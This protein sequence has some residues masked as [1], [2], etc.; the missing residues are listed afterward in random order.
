MFHREGW[1][2]RN[3]E[4]LPFPACLLD[5]G[6][7]LL[8]AS[9]AMEDAT[10]HPENHPAEKGP[11]SSNAGRDGLAADMV[12]YER[13]T[14][15][16][17]R[18]YLYV[19]DD[20]IT[21]DLWLWELVQPIIGEM[22]MGV[23]LTDV[24]LRVRATNSTA[25]KML[26]LKADDA[27]GRV[28]SEAVPELG[29]VLR[30]VAHKIAAEGVRNLLFDAEIDGQI[31]H[32]LLDSHVFP[33]FLSPEGS[34]EK[35][36]VF[37]L[38]DLGERFENQL[39]RQEKLAT[40]GKIAAGIAHEIRN[41]LTS[42]KGFLQIMRENFIRSH[43]DKEFQYTEVMLAEIDR[44]NELVG[45]LLLLSRPRDIKLASMEV[46]EL[47]TGLAP[48]ISSETLLHDIEFHLCIKPVPKVLA[49]PELLKQVVLNLVKNAVEAMEHGGT[50]TLCTDV[51]REENLV[52][53]D[54]QDTGPGIPA[55]AM[56]R[57]FDAFFTTKENGTGLGLPICQRIIS[58]LGGMIRVSSKG[59]GTTFSVL[60]PAYEP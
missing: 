46:E 24:D 55:Y 27:I 50:L 53:I 26:H 19:S 11:E 31:Q 16:G 58:D 30:P 39:Q 17:N 49:D 29:L 59:Y 38:K 43:M 10:R 8:A 7:A 35:R 3:I 33:G 14:E 20:A 9:R 13:T 1:I 25:V 45:E 5:S 40:V 21:W 51:D 48:L 52:R 12:R 47:V 57:I 28:L 37:F 23:I 6:G 4:L 36:I 41:P 22:A 32:W 34:H 18:V 56:D 15:D 60:L 42:I 2:E 54:V 44:V